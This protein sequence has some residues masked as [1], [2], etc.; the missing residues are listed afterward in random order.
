MRVST[1]DPR[2]WPAATTP[3]AATVG[4]LDGVHIGHRSLLDTLGHDMA[5]TVLTFDP[6]PVEVLRPGTHPRLLTTITERVALFEGLGIDHVGVLDLHDVKEMAPEAFVEKVLVDKAGVR[7]LVTGADFRFGK[8]RTGDV[9]LL[10]QMGADH[11]FE[12][13]VA[14]LVSDDAGVVS[15]SR[16]RAL[17]EEGR[18]TEAGRALGAPFRLTGT[19]IHGD[20]RGRLLGFPTANI[21][22]P[23][24]KV[25]PAPGVYAGAVDVRGRLLP[26]AINVGVRPTFGIGGLVVEAHI[27]DF[28]TE[29]YGERIGVELVSYLR[30]EIAFADPDQ[31]VAQMKNDVE[32]VR[33]STRDNG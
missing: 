12:V 19:V 27:L 29:I 18:P 32:E 9:T 4:V 5:R 16:I 21:A 22:P 1:G 33:S 7:R 8:D 14:S 31:L 26:A 10:Q 2:K 15:S 11:G 30:P 24:R 25:I 17:I 20:R 13:V 23:A 28:D 3:A 6:H